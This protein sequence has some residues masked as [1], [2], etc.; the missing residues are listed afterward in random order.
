[1]RSSLLTRPLLIFDG[2]CKF[3]RLW[4]ERWKSLT[5]PHIDYS[6]YQEAAERFPEIPPEEF[7]KS[8]Q[9]VSPDGTVDSG[10]RAV[11]RT[12]SLAHRKQW[13]FWLYEN[14]PGF[15]RLS[16]WCYRFIAGRRDLFSRWT[17]TLWGPTMEEPSYRL[18]QSFFLRCVGLIYLI[19]F[20][21][22]SVQINGLIGSGGILPASDFLDAVKLR[23]GDGAWYLFPT[24]AWFSSSDSFLTILCYG[25]TI[26]SLLFMIGLFPG[27]IA[28]LLWVFYFSL[29]WVGQDFLS[30]QWDILLLEAGFLAIFF[31][32]LCYQSWRGNARA[33][34]QAILW[35][36]RL[37]LFRLMFQSGIVKLTSGD[38]SWS[39][40]T[41]LTFHYETQCIPT[42]VAWYMHQLPLWFHQVS[43][44]LM[45]FVEI[46]VPF[47]IFMP[48]RPRIVGACALIAFQVLIILTG[49]YTFFN[50][51]TIVLCLI[52]FEDS[53][54]RRVLPKALSEK[55]TRTSDELH[56]SSFKK[57]AVAVF[58][59]IMI[60]LNLV[61]LTG[62]A[63][64]RRGFHEP[65][66]SLFQWSS[67]Y[68]IVNSYGLFRVLTTSR[69][70][71]VVEGS[72]DGA[73][74]L[75][76]EFKYKPGDTLRAPPWVAPHQPRLDWQMWFAAL[77]NY[78]S[79]R[80]FVNFMIRL[81]EG[82]PSVTSL[83]GYNPFPDE[84]PRYVRALLYE[85]HFT[86]TGQRRLTGS[87]WR[88]E[89]KGVYLP[90]ISL[91]KD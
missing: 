58:V 84:P 70:E 62:L 69:P 19:A 66:A 13:L 50:Y 39:N 65:I 45:F 38:Q 53:S 16:E 74:W 68:A 88:R 6:P 80:W 91:R 42:P 64:E 86:D 22:L 54:L 37:L 63:M 72:N 46:I 77:G 18:T 73:T 67:H 59:W 27:P 76:Y 55:I 90:V 1:M 35:L 52:L 83:L 49:N 47:T 44:V 82:S 79:N 57:C 81:L 51:L 7:R 11:L 9:L 3:C 20:V 12:L 71:I 61:H 17:V 75:T 30:F 34:S 28:F 21:S 36:F 8:V 85:Y 10:A 26:L 32:P 41:A 89:Y 14:L 43:V 23:F 56:D 48:R 24:V 87:Y 4:I 40:L 31:S 78:N 25:G 33:P 2:D 60:G 15:S 5:S 29:Y